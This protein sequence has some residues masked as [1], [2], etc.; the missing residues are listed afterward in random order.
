MSAE[1]WAAIGPF[2]QPPDNI[3]LRMDERWTDT[4]SKKTGTL[5]EEAVQLPQVVH[6][7]HHTRTDTGTNL[8]IHDGQA[9]N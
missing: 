2:A 7:K 5:G 9:G 8:G 3:W 6:Q 1:N 4:D